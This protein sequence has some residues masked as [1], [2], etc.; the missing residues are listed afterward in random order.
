MAPATIVAAAPRPTLK[1]VRGAG[2]VTRVD[3]SDGS[4]VRS[5]MMVVGGSSLPT[6]ATLWGGISYIY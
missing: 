4:Q 2:Q 1:I 6:D 5:E 3:G